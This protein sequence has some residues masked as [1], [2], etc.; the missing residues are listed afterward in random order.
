L[1]FHAVPAIIF[2]WIFAPA[3]GSVARLARTGDLSLNDP[4]QFSRFPKPAIQPQ[5]AAGFLYLQRF[6]DP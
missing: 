6:L 5:A 2:L 1:Q 4:T 3:V